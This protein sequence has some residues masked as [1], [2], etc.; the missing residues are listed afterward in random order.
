MSVTLESLHPSLRLPAGALEKF[1]RKWQI[2]RLEIFGSALREDF[3]ERSD[4][5][6]L[7]TF[8]PAA[9]VGWEIG[10]MQDELS[11]VVSR[12]VDLVSRASIERSE[13]WFRRSAILDHARVIYEA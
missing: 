3:D 2:V 5:D 9:H 13:N 1:C 8:A 12:P 11:R 10:E 7:Y 6:F 4:V